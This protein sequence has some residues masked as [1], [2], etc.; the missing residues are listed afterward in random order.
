M[1]SHNRNFHLHILLFQEFS[2]IVVVRDAVSDFTLYAR[3]CLSES[4]E[5]IEDILNEIDKKF[6]VS[7]NLFIVRIIIFYK[8]IHII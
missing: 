4:Q 7:F 2:M 5:A 1:E 8:I 6:G 3:K